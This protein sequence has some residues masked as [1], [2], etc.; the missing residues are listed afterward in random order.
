MDFKGLLNQVLSSGSSLA[1]DGKNKLEKG[2]NIPSSGGERSAM[3]SGMGKGALAGS[4]LSLL[5]GSKKGRKLAGTAAGAGGAAALG[6]LALKTYKDWKSNQS[7]GAQQDT[8][9]MKLLP[10]NEERQSLIILQAMIAAAKAD[11]HVDDTEKERI[12]EVVKSLGATTNVNQFVQQELEKPL[13]PAEVASE[14]YSPEEAAE[15]YL[16]SLLVVDEQNFME[17]AYLQELAKQLKLEPGLVEKLE[18]QVQ[19]V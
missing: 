5:L 7:E 12:Q 16:A 17:K 8:T 4:A 18:A 14:V 9:D 19:N 15:V 10:E 6:A 13:D 2:L 1:S 11:G 3:L